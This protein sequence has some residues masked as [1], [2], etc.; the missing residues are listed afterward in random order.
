MRKPRQDTIEVLRAATDAAGSVDKW[1]TNVGLQSNYRPRVYEILRGDD[2]SSQAE[3]V[4]RLM[5]GLSP[6]RKQYWR[7]CLPAEWRGIDIRK[8]V[9][10]HLEGEQH[11][12]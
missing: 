4:V 10:Q 12:G 11:E 8:L 1:L 2:V 5:L 7:P 9:E 3:R 6:P